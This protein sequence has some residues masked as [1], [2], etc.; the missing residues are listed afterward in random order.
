MSAA[1]SVEQA[2]LAS[3]EPVAANTNG[4]VHQSQQLW[5]DAPHIH[6]EY[7]DISHVV[8]V[9][10]KHFGIPSLAQSVIDA[11]KVWQREE[12]RDVTTLAPSSGVV[13]PGTMTLVLAPPG[14]GKSSL[15]R[16][17]GKQTCPPF[18]VGDD[19]QFH[20]LWTLRRRYSAHRLV[21]LSVRILNAGARWEAG[22][23]SSIYGH[24]SV[25][26]SHGERSA[27]SRHSH[28]SSQRVRRSAGR[29]HRA[30]Y[31]EGISSTYSPHG[32]ARAIICHQARAHIEGSLTLCP[33]Q[34][35]LE[36]ALATSVPSNTLLPDPSKAPVSLFR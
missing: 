29:A 34:E 8:S 7:R 35:T 13:L 17:R 36:F 28:L 20:R 31:C 22:F 21:V 24:H 11:L 15:L 25:Q 27:G 2:Q 30:A 9:P 3:A 16:V 33:A 1:Q 32:L 18:V 23:R 5:V 14:H 19:M 6:I 4:E 10:V 26:R 12:T